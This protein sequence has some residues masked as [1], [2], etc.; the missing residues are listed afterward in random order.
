MRALIIKLLRAISDRLPCRIIS[1]ND[2]P[3]LERYYI[4]TLFGV[5]LYLHRFVGSD[6]DRGLHDH[7][8][9][10]LSSQAIL[11]L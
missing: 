3:Y 9:G 2:Q 6:P 1:D 8:F 10:A 5:R 7:L 4:A 11:I